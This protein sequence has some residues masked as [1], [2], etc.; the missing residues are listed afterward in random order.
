MTYGDCKSKGKEPIKQ[1]T[2]GFMY[3]LGDLSLFLPNV[4]Q[5]C[6]LWIVYHY[7]KKLGKSL[8]NGCQ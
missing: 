2:A 6:I 1:L 7:W 4:L 8:K 5:S 3:D